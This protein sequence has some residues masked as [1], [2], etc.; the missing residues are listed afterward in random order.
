MEV[1]FLLTLDKRTQ[2]GHQ[3]A[4][5]STRQGVQLS[6]GSKDAVH[7]RLAHIAFA[8]ASL[9]YFTTTIY[10]SK[11]SYDLNRVTETSQHSQITATIEKLV[12][13][14]RTFISVVQPIAGVGSAPRIDGGPPTRDEYRKRDPVRLAW[15]LIMCRQERRM[16]ANGVQMTVLMAALPN[17]RNLKEVT[18]SDSCGRL[19]NPD[20]PEVTRGRIYQT[21]DHGKNRW[22]ADDP[23]PQLW[24]LNHWQRPSD[25]WDAQS[26][27]FHGF[28]N[29]IRGLSS[30]NHGFIHTLSIQGRVIGVS[31]SIFGMAAK[32]F[33][34]IS[35][36]FANLRTLKLTI[37][38]GLV[39]SCQ[40]VNL[41]YGRMACVL[42]RATLLERLEMSFMRID[43]DE[44]PLRKWISEREFD[45]AR[46]LGT[47]TWPHL[48][49]SALI[50]CHRHNHYGLARLLGRHA[51]IRSLRLEMLY[52]PHTHLGDLYIEPREGGVR[53]DNDGFHGQSLLDV[54]LVE[55]GVSDLVAFLRGHGPKPG[56]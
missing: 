37:D 49:H 26:T 34:Q 23:A 33:R 4:D 15:Y 1:G 29:L 36:V 6:D 52:F 25:P 5:G 31:Q 19:T 40:E 22:T 16:G 38:D 39:Q 3:V 56:L 51:S 20:R 47:F 7:T 11:F 27:P 8:N 55:V 32:E 53:L 35:N 44:E 12:C 48:R 13:N 2:H 9:R 17:L 50:N 46:N 10:L 45:I 21:L 24:G 30:T 43:D 14:H 28:I 42:H 54:R 41:A 18:I